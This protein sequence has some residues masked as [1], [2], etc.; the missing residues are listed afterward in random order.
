LK[1]L[2]WKNRILA[3]IFLDVLE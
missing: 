2:S 3:F 1:G